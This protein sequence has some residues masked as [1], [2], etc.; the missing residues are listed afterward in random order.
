MISK[1]FL[2]SKKITLDNK[3]ESYFNFLLKHICFVLT[4]YFD[5]A[6]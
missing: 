3:L 1:S 4:F 2:F 6:I 5:L